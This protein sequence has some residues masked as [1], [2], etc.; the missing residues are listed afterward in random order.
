M[1]TVDFSGDKMKINRYDLC[2]IATDRVDLDEVWDA[3]GVFKSNQICLVETKNKGCYHTCSKMIIDLSD[4]LKKIDNEETRNKLMF[5]VLK[6]YR[7]E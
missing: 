3:F 6:E 7:E 5:W 2:G 4:F 1:S